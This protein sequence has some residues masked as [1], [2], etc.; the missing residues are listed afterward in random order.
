MPFGIEALEHRAALAADDVEQHRLALRDQL[1]GLAPG[2]ADDVAV[3]RAGET[4]VAGRDDDQ[5]GVVLARAG[6]QLRALRAAR[7]LRRRARRR[8]RSCASNRDGAASAFCCARRS[9]A[10]ATIFIALVIFCVDLTE[11]MRIL[12]ALR[13]PFTRTSCRTRS[14]RP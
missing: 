14:A 11:P 8:R 5:V 7:D 1:V 2:G 10:A 9:L 4:A 3:E 13:T 6:E 12:R